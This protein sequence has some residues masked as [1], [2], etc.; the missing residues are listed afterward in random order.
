MKILINLVSNREEVLITGGNGFVGGSLTRY[1]KNNKINVLRSIRDKC[2]EPNT[3]QKNLALQTDWSDILPNISMV[4]HT[5]GLAHSY[6]I[7]DEEVYKT[8]YLGTKKLIDQCVQHG[9]KY[10]I[11]FSSIKVCGENTKTDECF[12]KFSDYQVFDSYANSKKLIE[13]YLIKKGMKHEIK[14]LIIRSPLILGDGVRGNLGFIQKLLMRRIP[15]PFGNVKN[16]SKAIVK[17]DT[18]NDIVFHIV[19]NPD[20]FTNDIIC[21]VDGH[22]STSALIKLISEQAGITPKIFPVPNFFLRLCLKIS[23]KS[24]LIPKIFGDLKVQ[25]LDNV[26]KI[27]GAFSEK[28]KDTNLC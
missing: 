18:I 1:L 22:Y 4:I 7:D 6:G 9:V 3:V 13:L 11:F 25:D 26:K 15:I 17:I 12:N 21:P 5:A 20:W 2:A 23:G 14:Y 24:M 27:I 16:N 19:R 8:N 28:R 10:F